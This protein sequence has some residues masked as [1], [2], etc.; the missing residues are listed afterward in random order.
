MGEDYDSVKRVHQIN[1]IHDDHVRKDKNT[2]K[3]YLVMNIENPND[4]ILRNLV[5][6]QE[7]ETL[8]K[9][10]NISA[11][12][13]YFSKKKEKYQTSNIAIIKKC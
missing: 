1:F 9:K 10:L 8:E 13:N 6:V 5:I 7:K 4:F 3:R 12:N 2:I 11:S